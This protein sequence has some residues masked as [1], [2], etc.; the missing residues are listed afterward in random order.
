M[1]RPSTSTTKPRQI[2][3]IVLLVLLLL[4]LVALPLQ[5]A[6]PD[7]KGGGKG[8]GGG[9]GPTPEQHFLWR[10][11]MPGMYSMVRPV[12]AT[13]GTIYAVDVLDNLLAVAPDGT[14]KWTATDAGSKGVDVGPDGTIYTGNEN[15]VKAFNPD[16]TIKWTFVQNP[17]AFVFQDVAVGP[18][19]NIYGIGTSGMGVFSLADTPG[20]PVLRWSTPEAYS[21]PFTGYAEIEFGRTADG[22]D[23]QLYFHANGFT[24]AVRLSDG[25]SVFRGGLGN[26][27]PRVSPFDGTVHNQTS[28]F[29]P[30]GDLVWAFQFPLASG[31]IGPALGASGT[32][33]AVNSAT[34]L[35][36]IDPSGGENF[37]TQFDEYLGSPDVDPTE[38]VVLLPIGGTASTPGAVQAASASNGSSQWRMTFPATDNGL[39]QFVSSG[40]AFNSG[41]DT[42]YVMTSNYG[43]SGAHGY[44]N[45]ISADGRTPSASTLLRATDFDMSSKSRR[46]SVTVTGV[47]TVTD[48]NLATISGA[49]VHGTWT[50]PDGS[51]FSQSATTSGKGGAKF[52]MSDGQ[53]MYQLTVTD[54]NLDGYTFDP[55]H[56]I[57][58]GYWYGS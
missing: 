12:V 36:S 13:D 19:G 38:T 55:T 32:H 8:G 50:L 31:T 37:S 20:G 11:E 14:V 29:T 41:G 52:S 30:D 47:V 35:Y 42:A 27:D 24:R 43:G 22:S 25:A 23:F 28:V 44:L 45:A 9:G 17:R 26:G 39:E 51:T 10:V 40:F 2:G 46:G 15:W 54:I 53:G 4:T 7:G 5:A 21:R 57:L 56:S 49:T 1:T 34:V 48:E 6:P 58:D 3:S 18:D 33:Y 16:G